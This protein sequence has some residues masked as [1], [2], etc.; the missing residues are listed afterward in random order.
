MT[1]QED[2]PSWVKGKGRPPGLGFDPMRERVCQSQRRK[3]E[4]EQGF[5]P[6]RGYAKL[7]QRKG[8]VPELGFDSMREAACQSQRRK[9]EAGL[10]FDSMRGRVFLGQ[11]K[12][13]V[14]R[15]GV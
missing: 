13:Q 2:M 7:S 8:Q 12:G 4:A 1:L 9:R 10:K 15:A 6:A 14:P 5:D 3:R 11:R